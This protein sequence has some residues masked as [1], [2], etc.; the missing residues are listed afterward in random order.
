MPFIPF[1]WL[2]ELAKTSSVIWN[3][4]G[5]NRHPCLVSDL[6]VKT[7][8]TLP[9]RMMFPIGVSLDKLYQIKMFILFLI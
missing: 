7:F 5:E 2:L 4:S 1:S 6:T 3:N 9:L 8:S